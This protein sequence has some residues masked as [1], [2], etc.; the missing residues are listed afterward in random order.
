MTFKLTRI[1]HPLCWVERMLIHGSSL[2]T[3]ILMVG[4]GASVVLELLVLATVPTGREFWTCAFSLFS[5][6]L[7]FIPSNSSYF[8]EESPLTWSY[9]VFLQTNLKVTS[10]LLQDGEGC[11]MPMMDLMCLQRSSLSWDLGTFFWTLKTGS[12]KE[13]WGLLR[14][15]WI[16]AYLGA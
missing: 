15:L 5:P 6:V 4:S 11:Q 13:H 1:Y 14:Y 12:T 7:H 9:S 10:D 2:K 8:K 3:L 16:V